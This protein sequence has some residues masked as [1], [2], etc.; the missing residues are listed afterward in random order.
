MFA[1]LEELPVLQDALIG[2]T[3]GT[4]VGNT[5]AV[6]RERRYKGAKRDLVVLR[7]AW[8]GTGFALALH[9]WSA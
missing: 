1:V 2:A 8:V 9:V 5:V 3:L 6:R 7:W 4:L